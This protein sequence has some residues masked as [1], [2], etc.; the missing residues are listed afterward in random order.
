MV[1]EQSKAYA[2]LQRVDALIRQ[3]QTGVE[4]VHEADF[5]IPVKF[6]Q[7]EVRAK[8][9]RSG[10]VYRGVSRRLRHHVIGE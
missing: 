9:R 10:E 5:G 3:L 7:Q 1:P 4:N 2:Q 6:V 8:G